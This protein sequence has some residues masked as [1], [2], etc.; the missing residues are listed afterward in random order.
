MNFKFKI[1]NF[2]FFFI[3]LMGL[4]MV[5]CTPEE[6]QTEFYLKD[7]QGLWRNDNTTTWY[8]RFTDEQADQAGY[9]W[10]REWGDGGDD[11]TEEDLQY[12]GNGWFQY[13]LEIKG[14]LHEIHMMDNQGAPIP[15][16]YIVTL[17]TDKKLI[18]HKKGYSNQKYRF[19]K[20]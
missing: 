15:Q 3:A 9:L 2:K 16:E 1:S 18:Y 17:L 20:Q 6:D 10:G 4:A 12:H 7:L 8:M 14:D 19:T 11:V 5:A 13:Q